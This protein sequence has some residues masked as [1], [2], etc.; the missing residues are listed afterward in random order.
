MDKK[1]EKPRELPPRD[2]DGVHVFNLY[3]DDELFTNFRAQC[4]LEN[5]TVRE[6]LTGWIKSSLS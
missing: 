4:I 2:S 3:I 6:K 1:V 5:M